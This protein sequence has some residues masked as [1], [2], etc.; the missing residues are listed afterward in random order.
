[1]DGDDLA[2][3]LT[4]DP[5]SDELRRLAATPIVLPVRLFC[6]TAL[7]QKI[8]IE[9]LHPLDRPTKRLSIIL[10]ATYGPVEH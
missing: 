10:V 5:S 9:D 4:L 7:G 6:Y 1:M 3:A 8:T 2:A